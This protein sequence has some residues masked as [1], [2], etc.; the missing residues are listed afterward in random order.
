MTIQDLINALD[1]FEEIEKFYS[2]FFLIFSVFIFSRVN[3][4][5][6]SVV[7]V[8]LGL[9]FIGYYHIITQEDKSSKNTKLFSRLQTIDEVVKTTVLYKDPD[10]INLLYKIF[11]YVQYNEESYYELV[12]KIELVIKTV[13]FYDLDEQVEQGYQVFQGIP[14]YKEEGD[15]RSR[16]KFINVLIEDIKEIF[17]G[18]M[19]SLPGR[20]DTIKKDFEDSR[21]RLLLLLIRQKDTLLE[22]CKRKTMS[23]Y[24]K[25][26]N[27]AL[28]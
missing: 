2:I 19:Y 6:N 25:N 14:V 1:Q 22:E 21:Y 27:V 5:L 18:F 17:N 12:K 8:F 26:F 20:S 4:T 15:C 28:L 9:V 7:G 16:I 23:L 11:Y 13:H 24:S 10:M 3:V